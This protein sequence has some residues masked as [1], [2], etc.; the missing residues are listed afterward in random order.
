MAVLAR[1]LASIVAFLFALPLCVRPA[2]AQA[3][4]IESEVKAAFLYNF[5]KYVDWPPTAFRDGS[6][7]F[8]M[9]VVARPE[10]V[11]T[12]DGLVSGETARG[13]P[14]QLLTPTPAQL[15]RCHML[16]VG[17]RDGERLSAALP[18]LSTRPVLTVVENQALFDQG[19][20]ILL[21]V[22]QS[23]IRF[24]ISLTSIQRAGLTVSSKLLRV[25]RNIRDEAPER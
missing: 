24:D 19:S 5:T 11:A 10:F 20:A 6:E 8:R 22:D 16:F 23:R 3:D 1:F 21:V 17:A 15:G 9:C 4:T 7:P 12:V 13:R 18:P 25:A 14:I 2:F